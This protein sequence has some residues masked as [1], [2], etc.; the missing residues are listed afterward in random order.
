MKIIIIII[1]T[2]FSLGRFLLPILLFEGQG[3][4]L[5]NDL[6][7][8]PTTRKPYFLINKILFIFFWPDS[9]N[10]KISFR[11]PEITEPPAP[12]SLDPHFASMAMASP[13]PR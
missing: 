10:F 9:S 7:P 3:T 5:L 12:H 11:S 2:S 13:W 8:H 6:V 1:I 4:L